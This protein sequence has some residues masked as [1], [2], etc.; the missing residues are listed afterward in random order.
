M[1][2]D[3]DAMCHELLF[4]SKIDFCSPVSFPQLPSEPLSVKAVLSRVDWGGNEELSLM[5]NIVF[6]Q[7][8]HSD[9]EIQILTAIEEGGHPAQEQFGVPSDSSSNQDDSLP[10]SSEGTRAHPPSEDENLQE[11]I[12][13]HLQDHPLRAFINWNNYDQMITDIAHHFATD[14]ANVVDA[15]EV[16]T[17]LVGLPAGA[18][19]VIV[20]LFPDIAVGQVARLVLFDV[21]FHAHRTEVNFR[22]GP[23]TQRFVLPVPLYADRSDIL[24]AA[25][26]EKYCEQKNDRCFVW[27]DGHI[28]LDTDLQ[29]RLLVHGDHV[30]IAVPPSE[31]Y[32]CSTVQL[33]E[34]T[35]EGLSQQEL[36]DRALQH[37]AV[38]G[39]SPSLLAEEDVRDLAT[40][41]SSSERHRCRYG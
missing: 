4:G 16:T 2:E 19:P 39:Y 27:Y 37:E 17:E 33:V 11:V 30:R 28:W 3:L 13:F 29:R 6:K 23:A 21:E 41:K 1:R 20:H 26:V 10:S 5:Q 12:M 9:Q 36:L 32:E 22:L 15:Y 34:W 38:A 18:V 25:N 35:Q 31:R 14:P 24:T 7:S 40:K 8:T